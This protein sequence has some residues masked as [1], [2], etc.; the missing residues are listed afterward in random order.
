MTARFQEQIT[1]QFPGW[2]RRFVATV[3]MSLAMSTMP[4]Y[5]GS[6]EQDLLR[7]KVRAA[8]YYENV[9]LAYRIAVVLHES[10][11]EGQR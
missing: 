1:R 6:A 10:A 2:E 4:G 9:R 8:S 5:Y 11:E 7:M 3:A